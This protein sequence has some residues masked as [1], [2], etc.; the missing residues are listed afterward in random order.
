MTGV[1]FSDLPNRIAVAGPRATAEQ[2]AP[3]M[4]GEMAL[5]I[6][7]GLLYS[8]HAASSLLRGLRDGM[9]RSRYRLR[10]PFDKLRSHGKLSFRMRF[11][12]S[13]KRKN[14]IRKNRYTLLS[15]AKDYKEKR[16]SDLHSVETIPDVEAFGNVVPEGYTYYKKLVEPREDLSLPNA[17]LKWYNIRP[18]DVEITPEQLAESRAFVAAEAERLKLADEL[19]FVLLHRAGTMLLLMLVTWRNTNELWESVYLKDLAQGGGYRLTEFENTHRGTYC[20]WEL[21]PVWHERHAWVQFLSSKR[22]AEAKLAYVNDRF[23]GL[24]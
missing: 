22:D 9:P 24:V 19:G 23:S 16:M 17:Y 13:A 10:Q 7:P 14:R 2:V 8:R 15:R 6:R 11:L 1:A 5:S 20:V 4:L 3:L 18:L 12:R 21:G